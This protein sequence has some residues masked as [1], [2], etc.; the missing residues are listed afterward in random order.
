MLMWE[1]IDDVDRWDVGR[2]ASAARLGWVLGAAA[3]A[4]SRGAWPWAR[5]AETREGG[6]GEGSR[7]SD[8]IGLG[9]RFIY[10]I[11]V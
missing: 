9:S 1:P 10:D 6:A 2:C 11:F 5:P 7:D 3:E 4:G 8:V